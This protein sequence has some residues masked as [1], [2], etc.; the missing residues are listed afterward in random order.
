MYV[1]MEH[2]NRLKSLE[3]GEWGWKENNGGDVP[4]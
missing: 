2:W 1:N 3:E 4:N